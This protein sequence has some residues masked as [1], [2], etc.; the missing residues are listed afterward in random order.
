M[1]TALTTY[2][3]GVYSLILSAASEGRE[4]VI[5]TA[6]ERTTVGR[7]ASRKLVTWRLVDGTVYASAS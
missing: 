4:Q 1:K 5:L 2:D 7:L 3:L 6:A